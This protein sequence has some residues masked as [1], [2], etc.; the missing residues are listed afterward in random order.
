FD[1]FYPLRESMQI[2]GQAVE[3][4]A[5]SLWMAEHLGYRESM[6]SC[7]AFALTFPGVKVVPTAISPYL[8]HPMPTASALATLDEPSPGN[9][10]IAVGVG[11]P[12]FLKESGLAIDRPIR[13]IDDFTRALRLLWSGERVVDE[14]LCHRLDGA[15]LAFRP[16]RPIPVYFAPMKEQMLRLSGRVADGVV[17]SGG[18]SAEFVRHSLALVEEGAL[19]ASRDP[20]ALARAG[21]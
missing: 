5:S 6:T 3:S 17:L 9:V 19:Q 20:A 8:R 11:N 21:Y 4:G 15:Q 10:A 1:G 14:G 12:M 16:S 13:A 7:M 2:A 18:L